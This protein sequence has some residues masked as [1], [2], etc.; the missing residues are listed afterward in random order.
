MVSVIHRH[1]VSDLVSHIGNVMIAN[2]LIPVTT[3]KV[4]YYQKLV[5]SVIPKSVFITLC[6]QICCEVQCELGH[7][8][9]FHF[10]ASVL[11]A[12]QFAAE[13]TL[14]TMFVCE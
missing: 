9:D 6:C 1:Q 5:E 8:E 7:T 4:Q 12:L 2:E 10:Q 3:H 14:V 13:E 11:D